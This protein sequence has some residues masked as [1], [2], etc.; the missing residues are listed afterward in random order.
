[1]RLMGNSAFFASMNE[2]LIDFP[3]WRKKRRAL[4][5]LA[6]LPKNFV[7]PAKPVQLDQYIF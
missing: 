2:N 5:K 3:P 6:F 4:E 7:L 1:M